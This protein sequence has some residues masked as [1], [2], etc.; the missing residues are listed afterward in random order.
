[1]PAARSAPTTARCWRRPDS[2]RRRSSRWK[3][4]ACS[5]PLRAAATARNHAGPDDNGPRTTQRNRRMRPVTPIP[6]RPLRR[7]ALLPLAAAAARLARPGILRAQAWP[8]RPVRMVVPFPPGGG[9]DTLGRMFAQALSDRLGQPVVIENRGG[10]GGN[11]GSA[12]V[13]QSAPAGL[14]VLCHGHGLAV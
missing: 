5:P 14:P 1:R 2:P 6:S 11:I 13:A 10:A 9:T 3:R 7:R 4:P 12:L 8:T